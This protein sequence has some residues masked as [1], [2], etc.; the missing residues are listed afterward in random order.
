MNNSKTEILIDLKRR[1]SGFYTTT[2]FE[3]GSKA[4]SRVFFGY[5]R[6]QDVVNQF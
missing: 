6:I 4:V 5:L 1:A 2:I 3:S